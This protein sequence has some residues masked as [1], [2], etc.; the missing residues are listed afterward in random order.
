MR[1]DGGDVATWDP[2]P[3]AC[4]LPS[5]RIKL[6]GRAEEQFELGGRRLLPYDVQLAVEEDVPE[7]AGVPFSIL[8]EG[9]VAGRLSLIVPE[10]EEPRA[11]GA[12]FGE[13]LRRVLHERFQ[14]PVDVRF[15]P[16]LALQ[17]KG[18]AGIVS[19]REVA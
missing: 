1:F 17:F 3:C 9:L 5:P 6:L 18:V 11:G 14:V 16:Q 12:D 7:L 19:E 15:T 2:R 8:R 4:G 13:A 10:P